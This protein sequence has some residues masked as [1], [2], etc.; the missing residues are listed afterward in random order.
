[1]GAKGKHLPPFL[2]KSS[3][4]GGIIFGGLPIAILIFFQ[5]VSG[6]VDLPS[7]PRGTVPS[8]QPKIRVNELGKVAVNPVITSL[9]PGSVLAGDEITLQ[10]TG[11]GTY[12]L[13]MKVMFGDLRPRG[14]LRII[15]WSETSIRVSIPTSVGTGRVKVGIFRGDDLISNQFD[16]TVV[17]PTVIRY[18]PNPAS[19]GDFVTITIRDLPSDISGVTAGYGRAGNK[20]ATVPI[21]R[22]LSGTNGSVVVNLPLTIPNG[23]YW[24]A[25]YKGERLISTR[26]ETLTVRTPS[27]HLSSARTNEN[28]CAGSAIIRLLGGPFERG[29]DSRSW[30]P[31]KTFVEVT[32]SN[33]NEAENRF[34]NA[35]I[36]SV[37]IMPNLRELEVEIGKCFLIQR[38]PRIRVIYPDH[39]K[40]NWVPV[41]GPR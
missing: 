28:P 34:W 22:H 38:D 13:G 5:S 40:S 23:S 29:T 15:R 17:T 20:I 21:T 31:G 30:Q 35:L 2:N 39:S 33:N 4:R 24:I 32:S 27:S 1:M 16:L 3:L 14:E 41:V 26:Q 6:A 19:P 36:Y 12:S 18:E 7:L 8:V 25:L 11:F 37:R 9:I 10:G